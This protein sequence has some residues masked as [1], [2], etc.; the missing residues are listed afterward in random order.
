MRSRLE[1]TWAQWFDNHGFGWQYEPRC[2]ASQNGQYLP[3]FMLC[4]GNLFVDIKGIM[5]DHGTRAKLFD[6]MSIITQSSP[7]VVLG[8]GVGN[9]P[10]NWSNDRYQ[11]PCAMH[12]LGHR[13]GNQVMWI[14]A[15]AVPL[16][17]VLNENIR[18][19]T[20]ER[21]GCSERASSDGVGVHAYGMNDLSVLIP[22]AVN[23]GLAVHVSEI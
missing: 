23:L 5:S 8:I 4:Q 20:A 21:G 15:V 1:A 19:A 22:Q 2:Y 11:T 9:P 6:R 14:N 18:R 17:V 13:H 16:M 10:E 7:D 12:Y 3:D